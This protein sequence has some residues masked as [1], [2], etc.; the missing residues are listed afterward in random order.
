LGHRTGNELSLVNGIL[1]D[2][3]IGPG[4]SGE[5]FV[6]FRVP[7]GYALASA[8]LDTWGVE[9]D[10]GR[11]VPIRFAM[12]PRWQGRRE[13][14]RIAVF[15]M[16]VH[17]I[18]GVGSVPED[19]V[20]QSL[21]AWTQ[22]EV[23]VEI[24]F[25]WYPKGTPGKAFNDEAAVPAMVHPAFVVPRSIVAVREKT[26]NLGA[27]VALLVEYFARSKGFK[28]ILVDAQSGR[29][30]E[31]VIELP[32]KDPGAQVVAILRHD[33]ERMREMK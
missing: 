19:W 24:A 26:L 1:R 2:Q 20:F 14:V 22:S 27:E 29:I 18:W 30:L 10:T 11:S 12:T 15:P 33:F 32:S 23:N 13:P 5:G 16:E 21:A 28:S 17:G 25:T 7:E 8:V 4:A 31:T 9:P 6:Y 3:E